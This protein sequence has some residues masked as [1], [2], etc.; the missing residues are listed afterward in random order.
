MD[1]RRVLIE[2]D[3]KLLF[4]LVSGHSPAPW[5][6][7]S[8]FQKV[9]NLL[10]LGDFRL[11]N[12]YRESNSVADG[13]AKIA[14]YQRMSMEFSFLTLPQYLR[15]LLSLDRVSFPYFRVRFR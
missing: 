2:T 7:Y 4:D 8:A 14:S 12:I 11:F 15:G 5:A 1:V 10:Q 3:S 9:R 13:L 6:Y